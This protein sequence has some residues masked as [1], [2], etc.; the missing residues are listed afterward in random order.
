MSRFCPIILIA[1]ITLADGRA[2]RAWPLPD[3]K[4]EVQDAT[5]TTFYVSTRGH[6]KWTGRL[7]APSADEQNGPFATL[8]AARDAIRRLK[9]MNAL[10]GA[11]VVMILEGTYRLREPLALT[12]EDTGTEQHPITYTAYPGHRP[13]LSGG[14][15]IGDW[16]PS[17]GKIVEA[18]LPDVKSG[19]WKFNQLFFRG[20]RQV[21]A[22]W[23]NPD[24]ADPLYSGWAFIGKEKKGELTHSF[25]ADRPPKA[26]AHPEQAEVHVFPWYCWVNDIIPLKSADAAAKTITLA[27]RQHYD[28]MP[29][30]AGNRFRVE[31][32][33]EELDQPGEWC[34]R[35]DT[36]TLYFWP[37]ND[38][39]PGDVIAPVIDTLI[40]LR[41][42][43][44]TPVRHITIS[45]LTFSHTTSPFPEFQHAS[46]HSPALHG[47]G[48]TIKQGDGCRIEDNRF[49]ML[50]GDG[51]R[52]QGANH[53]HEIRR[54]EISHVGG[55]GVV[56]ASD[57][58]MNAETWSDPAVLRRHSG[59][60]PKLVRNVISD[61]HIHH[62][63]R[64][65]KNCGGVQLFAVNSIDTLIAH[66]HIHDMSDKGMV[67]Q[68]GFGRFIVEYN[69]MHHLG[70]EIA[71]TGG[72]MINRWFVL[73]DDPDLAGGNIIRFNR[74]RNCIGCG[75]YSEPRHPKGEGDKTTANGRIWTPYYTWGVYFDNSGMENVVFGN[76]VE[77]TV[78]GAVALPVGAPKNNLV[79]NNIFI[80]SS[81]N[82][83]DLRLAGENNR[84]RR[85]IISYSDPKA[86]L[87]AASQAAK[88]SI[89]ECDHNL[90][91]LAAK[92]EPQIRGI[93][94]FDDWKKLG[95]DQHSLVADPLFVDAKQGDYGLHPDS[96]A[97][98]LGFQPI[99]TDK[100]G[101]RTKA[102]PH[103]GTETR[104]N[105]VVDGH[106]HVGYGGFL[107]DKFRAEHLIAE[108]NRRGI[109][110]AVILPMG[111][112]PDAAE[113]D[114]KKLAETDQ[115]NKDYFER[116]V[117]SE[118]IKKAQSARMDHAEIIDALQVYPERFVGVYII[119]PW[120][121][122]EL[123]AAEEAIKHRG[124]RGLKLH[125]MLN[126]FPADHE[127]V[128]PVLKLARRLNVPVMF[129]TSF[130]LRTEPA[131]V[132]KVAA[133]F[134]DV[135][136]VMFHPGIGEF[137][138][139][140]IQAAREHA[141]IYLD[142]AHADRA[143][144]QA[145]LEQV[146][147]ER[148]L[149]GSDA[150]WGRWAEKFDLV[151][152]LTKSKHDVQRMVMGQNAARV[153]KLR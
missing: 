132:A 50:G 16:K 42:T 98:R 75:A 126:A 29:L 100:I 134:P 62:C 36:G 14:T 76:I 109:D 46:H 68:D 136:I 123:A 18:Q 99:P 34:L 120:L 22:R 31:N 59:G 57:G 30:L 152:E 82:Q 26:W 145:F 107:G 70:K 65:K 147:P 25:D 33:L 19:R 37:P 40:E 89:S 80:E 27:K 87:L 67:M 148:I 9:A 108:M 15:V 111:E 138:K 71:D 35:S 106:R 140:A 141:N 88:A 52:L 72:V 44:E 63:G 56:L 95:F 20:E 39:Q 119:N 153:M 28:F 77:S 133:R 53:R 12:S 129:H 118:S 117:I 11:A 4:V 21:R 45:G 137:H 51:V 3:A 130:G 91:F 131:R 103:A 121:G 13:V 8:T 41:G 79:E 149:Y 81:G 139:D 24:P 110:R 102:A 143:A 54:N 116:G 142:T 64:I 122:E 84:F 60:F 1:L 97:F 90:Y 92:E 135:A 112:I 58:E 61:N 17:T 85:N 96:P 114:A 78:L 150:P 86:M 23:P 5:T 115:S 101:P 128:D 55:A 151:Q 124:F 73:A 83:L 38:I 94:S 66:N 69:D 125:P 7:P 10:P 49:V 43:P 146:P 74:I 127:V 2:V 6:D 47:A 48:I 144:L 32:V 113:Q 104:Q 93:G 105:L